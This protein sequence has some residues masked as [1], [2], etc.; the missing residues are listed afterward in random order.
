MYNCQ[1][2]SRC[3]TLIF[4]CIIG[5]KTTTHAYV[6]CRTVEDMETLCWC[7]SK[8]ISIYAWLSHVTKLKKRSKDMPCTDQS[9][10][11]QQE[12]HTPCTW[13]SE[14]CMHMRQEGSKFPR[15]KGLFVFD[16]AWATEA[17]VPDA[18]QG[19]HATIDP[20]QRRRRTP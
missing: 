4:D 2:I 13:P 12:R 11:Y 9:D 8:D 16:S 10:A 7:M 18:I 19:F 14:T 5:G 15:P 17:S 20:E 1:V 6:F 3:N